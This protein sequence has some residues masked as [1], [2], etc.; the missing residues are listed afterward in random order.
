V[1]RPEREDK[2][3]LQFINSERAPSTQSSRGN[4]HCIHLSQVR[5]TAETPSQHDYKR[6][7]CMKGGDFFSC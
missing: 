7:G 3:S 2:I 1:E 4:E 6:S 5:G